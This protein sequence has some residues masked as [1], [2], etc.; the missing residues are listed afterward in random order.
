[1]AALPSAPEPASSA[2]PDLRIAFNE[3]ETDVPLASTSKLD[4]LAKTLTNNPGERV[5]IM[6]YASG[7]ET[8]G[9][10]PK[11]VSLARGIA[12]RNYLTSNKGIDIE[13]VNVKALGNKNQGAGPGDRVDVFI[14]K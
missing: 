8:T 13:R 4:N 12:I 14:L 9:I 5:T 7:P 11:R 10:Y 1:M 2:V 3:T 6:A